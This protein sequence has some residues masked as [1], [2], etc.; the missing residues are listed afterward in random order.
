MAR[1]P[2]GWKNW[3]ELAAARDR[4]SA[5]ASSRDMEIF[6]AFV[7]ERSATAAAQ[8]TGWSITGVAKV[9]RRLALLHEQQQVSDVSLLLSTRARNALRRRGVNLRDPE[10]RQ[11]LAASWPNDPS[12]RPLLLTDLLGAKA[13]DEIGAWLGLP[14]RERQLRRAVAALRGA[15]AAHRSATLRVVESEALLAAIAP[16]I[17]AGVPPTEQAE[18]A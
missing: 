1:L 13:L 15:V 9:M 11:R 18:R 2:R 8:V 10:A 17:D 12:G 14:E 4:L 7:R 16:A 6:D 3:D 5:I